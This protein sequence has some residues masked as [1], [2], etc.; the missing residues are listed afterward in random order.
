MYDRGEFF[1]SGDLRQY[2]IDNKQLALHLVVRNFH[3]QEP[4]LVD[5]SMGLYF[6]H[7]ILFV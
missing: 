1:K 3:L 2:A 7:Q 6:F 5:S 4:S